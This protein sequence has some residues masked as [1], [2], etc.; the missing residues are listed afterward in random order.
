MDKNQNKHA[1][2]HLVCFSGKIGSGKSMA[3]KYLI[4]NAPEYHFEEKF[5]A[6]NVKLIASII[7]GMPMSVMLDSAGKNIQM[8]QYRNMTVGQLQQFIGTDLFREHFDDEVWIKS[9]FAAYDP[10]VHDWAVSDVRFKN[11]ADYC[12]E[13]G[14]ILVRLEGDPMGVRAASTRDHSHKSETDLDDYKHFD[15]IVHTEPGDD[16]LRQMTAIIRSMLRIKDEFGPD[17]YK[18]ELRPLYV[19]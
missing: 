11:E 6:Y 15:I 7:S 18:H 2:S 8:K 17:A 9:M 5:F 1:K 4:E 3:A 19:I 16:K 13:M 12:R 10:A 14:G